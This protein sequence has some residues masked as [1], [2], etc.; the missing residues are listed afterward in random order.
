M[1][2]VNAIAEQPIATI[3]N[4]L[5]GQRAD[6]AISDQARY[7][8]AVSDSRRYSLTISDSPRYNLTISDTGDPNG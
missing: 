6:L 2:G 5:F 7:D 4:V 1:L 3:S 8:L